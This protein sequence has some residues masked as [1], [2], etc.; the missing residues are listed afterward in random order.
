[1]SDDNAA[2]L[3]PV[4][5]LVETTFFD[6]MDSAHAAD[7]QEIS[8]DFNKRLVPRVRSDTNSRIEA[9]K[10]GGTLI[11]HIKFLLADVAN[12]EHGGPGQG[13]RRRRWPGLAR[14]GPG[15]APGGWGS[16]VLTLRP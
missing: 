7:E 16:A 12:P 8:D 15:G 1:M 13:S 11:H 4:T 9:L 14:A 3:R 2:L 5:D 10:A 6:S